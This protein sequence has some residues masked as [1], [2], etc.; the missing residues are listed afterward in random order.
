MNKIGKSAYFCHVFA[1][2]IFLVLYRSITVSSDIRHISDKEN[3]VADTMS[4]HLAT[5]HTA[6][7]VGAHTAGSDSRLTA[8]P[9][10]THTVGLDS[11]H[12]ARP[13]S[14]VGLEE[15]LAGLNNLTS[16]TPPASAADITFAAMA[17]AQPRCSES[18]AAR[19]LASLQVVDQQ[20]ACV[21]M[22]CDISTGKARPLA[23]ACHRQQV[24]AALQGVVH[25]GIRDSRCL[26]SHRCGGG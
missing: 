9:A 19:R 13:D 11:C 24:F 15:A 22:W 1:N 17:E 26:I 23:P 2:N 21:S 3:V 18:Q 16:E 4:R 12:T 25:P 8:G 5:S 14:S 20:V 6:E 10:C 7:P